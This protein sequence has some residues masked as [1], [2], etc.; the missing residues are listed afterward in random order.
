MPRPTGRLSVVCV[1]L[2]VVALIPALAACS[3]GSAES[4]SGGATRTVVDIDEKKVTVPAHPTRVV[5][6]S[7]PT[8][9]ALVALGVKPVGAVNGRGQSTV[10]AYLAA[11]LKGVPNVGNIAQPNYEAIAKV[12]PDL[13]LV[14]GTSI[15][16]NADALAALRHI[17][18]TVYTGYAGGPWKLNFSITAD[19]LNRKTEADKVV[20]DYRA[21]VAAAKQKLTGYAGST[22]SIVRWQGGAPALILKELPAGEVLSD[23]G[24][25]RP[26]NQDRDGRGH[27][28]PVSLENISQIDADY[29]FFG[30]L[31]GSSVDNP[32]AGG[33]ADTTAATKALATAEKTPGFTR[34]K[35]Y[36]EGHI[37]AVDGSAWTSTGGP[38]LMA[39]IVDDVVK[40]LAR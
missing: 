5:A 39:G 8:L 22:F 35:A 33:S 19:A 11:K 6:L 25:K 27:S 40:E 24:L 3:S 21:K 15:N 9:D 36:R 34:L 17:A 31:G 12:K 2:C 7:E 18:P 37:V 30:T 4:S 26:K 38:V 32:D 16:N 29:L 20:A 23:L 13:I 10:P 1:L 28:E 14:D